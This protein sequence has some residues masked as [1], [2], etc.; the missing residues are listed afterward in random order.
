MTQEQITALLD[1][2]RDAAADGR[3][4]LFKTTAHFDEHSRKPEVARVEIVEFCELLTES[5][6]RKFIPSTFIGFTFSSTPR[7]AHV[8]SVQN[9]LIHRSS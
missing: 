1:R 7:M 2:T 5:G 8:S 6:G 4:E 3:F 9:G